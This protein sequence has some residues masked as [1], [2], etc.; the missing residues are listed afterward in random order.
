MLIVD[1]SLL[2]R[3]KLGCH[4]EKI[5]GVEITGKAC[6]VRS[7]IEAFH[8]SRP[9]VVVLD[10]QMGGGN[11]IDVLKEIKRD[12][13]ET[14]VIILTNHPFP[15]LAKRCREAGAEFFFDKTCEFGKVAEVLRELARTLAPGSAADVPNA[16]RQ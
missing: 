5:K 9:D 3:E 7:A 13:P 8:R 10:L 6:D 14:L 4:L 12:R 2:V 1:D 11:G 16:N 15:Q